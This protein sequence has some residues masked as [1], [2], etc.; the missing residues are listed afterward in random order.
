MSSTVPVSSI[1]TTE[2]EA[3]YM[4]TSTLSDAEREARTRQVASDVGAILKTFGFRRATFRGYT[5]V[6]NDGDACV[7]RAITPYV[8]GYNVDGEALDENSEEYPYGDPKTVKARAARVPITKLLSR[9]E[10]ALIVALVTNYEFDVV[11]S[12]D[13]TTVTYSVVD[14]DCG[15]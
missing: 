10:G 12:E 4:P 14:Y 3:Q 5:P 1:S 2:F 13:Q 9:L 7:H 6:F 15:Y 11:L 8:D